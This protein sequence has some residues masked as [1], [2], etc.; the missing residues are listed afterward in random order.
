ME[1][2]EE[3]FEDAIEQGAVAIERAPEIGVPNVRELEKR[4]LKRL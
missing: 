2:G 4:F 3:N 1:E